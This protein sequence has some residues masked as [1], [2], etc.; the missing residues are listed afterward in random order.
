MDSVMEGRGETIREGD[1]LAGGRAGEGTRL[2]LFHTVCCS[3]C[4]LVISLQLKTMV[5]FAGVQ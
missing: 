2:L 5:F 3:C 1:E 4:R